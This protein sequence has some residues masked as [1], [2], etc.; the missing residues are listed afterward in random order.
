MSTLDLLLLLMIA[1][2]APILL[3]KALGCLGDWPVDGGLTFGDERPLLGPSK[4]WRG[5]AA[6]VLATGLAAPVLGLSL[7]SGLLFGACAMLGDLVS[8]FAK[9]RL[10]IPSSGMALGLDQVPEALFPLL[11]VQSELNLGPGY[12]VWVVALFLLLELVLSRILYVL[13][14]RDHPH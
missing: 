12:I 5:L 10:A 3:K 6:A 1:N 11:S 14:I 9:R 2:G 13:H 4:T 8:S 7:G